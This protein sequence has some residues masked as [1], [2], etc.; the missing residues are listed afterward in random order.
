MEKVERYIDAVTGKSPE[1]LYKYIEQELRVLIEDMP[2][3]R[4][5]EGSP[6]EADIEACSPNWVIS[7]CWQTV[8]G[9]VKS[10]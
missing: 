4:N 6:G 7:P 5:G 2:A 8:S 3:D 9:W 10:T 1:K